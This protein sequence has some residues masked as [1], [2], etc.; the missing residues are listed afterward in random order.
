MR[1]KNDPTATGIAVALCWLA[2][3]LG[4]I[5]FGGSCAHSS[6]LTSR[7]LVERYIEAVEIEAMCVQGNTTEGALV[8]W[9]GSGVI[10]SRTR[11]LTASHVANKPGIVC[12]FS[13]TTIDGKMRMV[14]PAAFL[15]ELDLASLEIVDGEKPFDASPVSYG[16]KPEVGDRVC[17]AV[18]NPWRGHKCGEVQL[19]GNLP[20]DVQFLIIVEPGNSG[21]GVYNDAGELVGIVTHR[22]SCNQSTQTCGGKAASLEGHTRELLGTP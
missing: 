14:Q 6:P 22:F 3:M 15:P 1:I 20:G 8:G 2:V 12:A 9:H 17:A 4:M 11:V 18:A 19:P 21:S 16:A 7:G 13:A 5:A 10:V